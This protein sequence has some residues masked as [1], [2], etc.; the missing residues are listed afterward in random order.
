MHV[1]LLFC[2]AFCLCCLLLALKLI[3]PCV[4]VCCVFYVFC[5]VFGGVSFFLFYIVCGFVFFETKNVKQHNNTQTKHTKS[6]KKLLISVV[7]ESVARTHI[8][9]TIFRRLKGLRDPPTPP[10]S[11]PGL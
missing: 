11:S 2:Y 1:C 8:R 5:V 7:N 6:T 3:N 4:V 10:L 9:P